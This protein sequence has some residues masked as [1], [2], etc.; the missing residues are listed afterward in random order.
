[1]PTARCLKRRLNPK[2]FLFVQ[3]A[4][5]NKKSSLQI[6]P[7]LLQS[8]LRLS[9]FAEADNS[10]FCTD[11]VTIV[12]PGVLLLRYVCIYIYTHPYAS[13]YTYIYIYIYCI[14]ICSAVEPIVFKPLICVYLPFKG[15]SLTFWP[16]AETAWTRD[17][18]GDPGS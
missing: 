18:H 9:A 11:G 5:S 10:L 13:V 16:S 8:R 12:I 14:V 17:S 6:S 15:R 2:K 3:E 4:D 1:M 7:L